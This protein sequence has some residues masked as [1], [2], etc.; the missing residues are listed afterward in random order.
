MSE[1]EERF[2]EAL[3]RLLHW[4]EVYSR[5][6]FPEPIGRRRVNGSRPACL[7]V[8]VRSLD[9]NGKY[10]PRLLAFNQGVTEAVRELRKLV[11]GRIV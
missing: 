6:V 4:S 1:R 5:D 11:F 9:F 7:R 10:T 3:Q 2:E 8:S